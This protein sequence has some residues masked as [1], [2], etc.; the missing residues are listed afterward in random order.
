MN[1]GEFGKAYISPGK[2]AVTAAVHAVKYLVLPLVLITVLTMMLA[3]M[4]G[5][6]RVV[7]V[8]AEIRM[9][10]LVFGVVLAALGFLKGMYPMGSY[11]RFAFATTAAVLVIVYVYSMLL[12]GRAE[13]VI[14]REAFELDLDLLFVLYFFTAILAVLMQFAE[15]YDHRRIWMEG[16]GRIPAKELERPEDHRFYHDLR[17]RYGSLFKGLKL[18]RSTLISFVVLPLAIIFVLVAGFSS[19]DLEEMGPMLENIEELGPHML[20]IG[21]PLTALSFFKGFYPRGSLSR[22]IPAL[23]MVLITLYWIWTLG[24]EGKFVFDAIEEI[25]I[26]LDYTGLLLL[27]M[28]GMA[29]WIVYYVL[30]LLLHRPEW[31]EGGFQRDLLKRSPRKKRKGGDGSAVQGVMPE[32]GSGDGGTAGPESAVTPDSD[33]GEAAEEKSVPEG[34]RTEGAVAE[35]ESDTGEAAEA[36]S[37]PDNPEPPPQEKRES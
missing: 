33:A 27:I 9:L 22:L 35:A 19:L 18:T 8:L 6:Q 24:L 21:I 20:M 4:D 17:P 15:M 36:T 14:S 11:S 32:E 31:K 23:V 37:A 16:G 26:G 5:P 13:N 30:E 3:E 2:G 34:D 28:A 25:D 12:G 7:D 10:V 29:L 1:L